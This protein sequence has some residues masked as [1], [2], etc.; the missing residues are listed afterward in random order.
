MARCPPCLASELIILTV[1]LVPVLYNAAQFGAVV[2]VAC[3]VV[4][5]EEVHYMHPGTMFQHT[6]L[7]V[8]VAARAVDGDVRGTITVYSGDSVHNS[9]LTRAKKRWP[10][11]RYLTCGAAT[12][13]RHKVVHFVVAD[14][15]S[16]YYVKQDDDHIDQEIVE[17]AVLVTSCILVLACSRLWQCWRFNR[18]DKDE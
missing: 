17:G 4:A 1:L 7:T 11:G 18:V 14:L 13:R 8:T 9:E 15:D 6:N 16:R 3:D 2:P 10:I 5:T 12:L